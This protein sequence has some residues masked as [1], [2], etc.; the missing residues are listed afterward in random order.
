M[1]SVSILFGLVTIAAGIFVCVYGNVLFRFVIAVLG[2]LIGFWLIMAIFPATNNAL[3]V[4]L[5]IVVGGIG[6]AILYSLFRLALHV[7]GAL[8]GAVVVMTVLALIGWIGN[9]NFGVIS[10]ILVIAGAVVVGFFGNRLGNAIIPLATALAGAAA[11]VVGVS[12]LFSSVVSTSGD[13]IKI[14]S[15]G[16][17]F[18]LF[19]IIAIIS[20]L[21]QLQIADL[22]RRLLR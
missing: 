10:W 5:A 17:A 2:F 7:A 16:F 3:R 8:L 12:K 4:V 11:V 15:N 21:A 9:G 19:L 6:A 20:A 1:D 22:R 14:M 13:P 18:V